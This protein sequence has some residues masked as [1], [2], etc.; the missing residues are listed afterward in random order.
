MQGLMYHAKIIH[1]S[2]VIAMEQGPENNQNQTKKLF[3]TNL[4]HCKLKVCLMKYF[5]K[6]LSKQNLWQ[7]KHQ[8]TTVFKAAAINDCN[9]EDCQETIAEM[10]RL[11]QS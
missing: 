11:D 5:S 7:K 6:Y 4:W 1:P 3:I 9:N 2:N 8:H 10:Y